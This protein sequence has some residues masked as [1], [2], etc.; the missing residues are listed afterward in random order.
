MDGH[1]KVVKDLPSPDKYPTKSAFDQTLNR[2]HSH[3]VK[4]NPR[5]KKA[6][7]LDEI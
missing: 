3:K 6:S 4:I 5:L 2:K 1:I 7:Y